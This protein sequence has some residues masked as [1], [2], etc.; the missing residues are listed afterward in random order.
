[1]TKLYGCERIGYSISLSVSLSEIPR[2]TTLN[3]K[4]CPCVH[5]TAKKT[6]TIVECY[7]R[8]LFNF[9]AKKEVFKNI[10]I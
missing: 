8:G 6:P 9:K 1:M 10:S 4:T 2:R 5:C 3:E 7:V